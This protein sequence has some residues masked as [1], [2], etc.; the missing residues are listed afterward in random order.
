MKVVIIFYIWHALVTLTMQLEGTASYAVLLLA[1]VE[2]FILLLGLLPKNLSQDWFCCWETRY[3]LINM[4]IRQR[5]ASLHKKLYYN[6]K[7]KIN[8]FFLILNK[9]K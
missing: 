3:S 6:N 1:R 8:N 5:K 7:L 9:K 2:S 4:K